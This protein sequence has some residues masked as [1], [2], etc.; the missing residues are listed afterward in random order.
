MN[1]IYGE[2]NVY[3]EVQGIVVYSN[4]NSVGG[5]TNPGYAEGSG[6]V[7]IK[8]VYPGGIINRGW[9]NYTGIKDNSYTNNDQETIISNINNILFPM[10]SKLLRNETIDGLDYNDFIKIY[11]LDSCIFVA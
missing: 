5:S 1:Q 8:W 9:P 3:E 11:G 10:I 2:V 4:N 7:N 6:Q